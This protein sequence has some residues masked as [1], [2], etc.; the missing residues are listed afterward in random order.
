VTLHT[1]FARTN[2]FTRELLLCFHLYT[3]TW[4]ERQW[5]KH[6]CPWLS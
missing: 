6:M 5:S 3:C 4:L 1:S 2:T